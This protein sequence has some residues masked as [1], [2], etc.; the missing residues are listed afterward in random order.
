M[1][2]RLRVERAQDETG[3]T[4]S[5]SSNAARNLKV[6]VLTTVRQ[7]ERFLA[8]C[9]ARQWYDMDRAGFAFVTKIKNEAPITFNYDVSVNER[10]Q[11]IFS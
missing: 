5:G 7:L 8:K 9:V 4:G 2:I 6:E 1:S 11:S 3:S 10:F